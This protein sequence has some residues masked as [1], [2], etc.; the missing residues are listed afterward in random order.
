MKRLI[1]LQL[2]LIA[3]LQV[4]PE[5]I[6]SL[7][8]QRERL[9]TKYSDINLP[10][11]EINNDDIAKSLLI[12]K[13]VVI[14]DTRIIT[15]YEEYN[16]KIKAADTIIK[17]QKSENAALNN[18]LTAATDRLFII[19][20]AVGALVCMLVIAL[21]FLIAFNIKVR[22]LKKKAT[23][24]NELIRTA[25]S[26]RQILQQLN[27][28]IQIKDIALLDKDLA[29][30]SLQKEK[31]TLSVKLMEVQGKIEEL[32]KQPPPQVMQAPNKQPEFYDENIAKLEK[33]GRMKDMGIVTEEEFNI[34]RKKFLSEI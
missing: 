8:A 4:F 19:Y 6:D 16:S 21:V 1:V 33:L 7:K 10:G 3:S 2:I 9:Y 20:I 14:A 22:N 34:F 31:E 23:N 24:F 25:D 15:K 5:T 26:D 11:K 29:L 12:L 18:K 32:Q 13:D 17:V 28:Q 30:S 27:E